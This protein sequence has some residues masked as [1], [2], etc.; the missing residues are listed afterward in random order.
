VDRFADEFTKYDEDSDLADVD[1]TLGR[2]VTTADEHYTMV[3][4]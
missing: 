2:W 3:S 1:R 4:T